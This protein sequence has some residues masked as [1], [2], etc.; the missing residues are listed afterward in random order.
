MSSIADYKVATLNDFYAQSSIANAPKHTGRLALNAG[1]EKSTLPPYTLTAQEPYVTPS[2]LAER[3]NY[4]LEETPVNLMFFSEAN[5]SNLQGMIKNTVYEMSREKRYVID[6]QNEADLKTVMRSYYLQYG[7]NDPNRV[8]EELKELNDR[9]VNWCS[10][11]IMSEINAYVRYR[12]DIM[13]FPPPIENPVD[14]H[15]YG[16]R[17]GELKSFF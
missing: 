2:R 6:N 10:N 17:T 12:K 5:I 8:A 3:I 4:R 11:N 14:T 9:V 13:D 15:I 16:T 1:D 7:M